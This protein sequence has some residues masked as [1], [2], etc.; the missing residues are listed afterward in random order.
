MVIFRGINV[1]YFDSSTTLEDKKNILASSWKIDK[2][3]FI[4]LFMKA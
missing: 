4:I 2:K 3:N 1:D